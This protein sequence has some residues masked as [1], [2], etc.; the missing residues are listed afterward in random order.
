[1]Q[2]GKRDWRAIQIPLAAIQAKSLEERCYRLSDQAVSVLLS[3]S[4]YAYWKPR[5]EKD[6]PLTDA[7]RD[8]IDALAAYIQS[9]LMDPDFCAEDAVLDVRQ[10][11]EN[12]CILEK[13][14]DG[15]IIW[16][17]FADLS[18]CQPRLRRNPNTGRVNWTVDDITFFEIPDGPWTMSKY[19][20]FGQPPGRVEGTAD[21]QTC[22]AAANGAYALRRF[23]SDVSPSLASETIS[24]FDL[25]EAILSFLQIFT[26]PIGV[27]TSWGAELASVFGFVLA[28]GLEEFT[29]EVEADLKCCL[30]DN[31]TNTDGVVTFDF[32]GVTGCLGDLYTS[33]DIGTYGL[34]NLLLAFIGGPGLNLVA[35]VTQIT[36]ADCDCG[37]CQYIE[38]FTGGLKAESSFPSSGEWT[39]DYGHNAAGAARDTMTSGSTSQFGVQI[40]LGEDCL[41]DTVRFWSNVIFGSNVNFD[42]HVQLYGP[43]ME[44]RGLH[45]FDYTTHDTWIENE[46]VVP[47]ATMAQFVLIY[48]DVDWA[49]G[50]IKLVDDIEVNIP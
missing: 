50:I 6:T 26:D 46:W 12:P 34:L 42:F 23:Y 48:V 9:R 2:R 33:T 17:P 10:N 30:Y 24:Q 31:A 1:M 36:D 19:P 45:H 39:G 22:L 20:E 44:N 15:G 18:L 41:I 47:G 3:L 4:E 21:E 7:E 5:W 35:G 29:D 16:T 13:S 43:A 11:E 25:Y 32:N 49:S 14:T 38:R 28:F 8:F 40:D 37:D 27:M